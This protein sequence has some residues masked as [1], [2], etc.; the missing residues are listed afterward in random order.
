MNFTSVGNNLK[1]FIFGGLF[2]LFKN[3]YLHI[4]FL[5]ICTSS[6][7]K[8]L[9]CSFAHFLIESLILWEFNFLSFL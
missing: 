5:A 2:D 7:E 1:L 6:F 3:T 9:P 4:L 8:F